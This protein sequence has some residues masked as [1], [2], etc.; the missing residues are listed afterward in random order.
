MVMQMYT[1]LHFS[2]VFLFSIEEKDIQDKEQCSC[3]ALI[4][5]RIGCAAHI[6]HKAAQ[7]DVDVLSI[8]FLPIS[9]KMFRHFRHESWRTCDFV[10]VEYKTV[11][12]SS[13]TWW[14]SVEQALNI[15]SHVY[16]ALKCRCRWSRR[17]VLDSRISLTAMFLVRFAERV[18]MIKI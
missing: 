15:F 16:E 10:D 3:K 6:V 7:T 1:V 9:T 17:W 5:L 4:K 14:M 18:D 12:L 8:H 13:K 2:F 11:L